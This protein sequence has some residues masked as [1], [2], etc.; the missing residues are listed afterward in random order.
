MRGEILRSGYLGK[1]F[2][3]QNILAVMSAAAFLL[4]AVSCG[5]V[6][7]RIPDNIGLGHSSQ[8]EESS[9]SD[10]D[11]SCAIPVFSE[12]ESMEDSS[13][14]SS[15]ESS[16]SEDGEKDQNEEPEEQDGNDGNEE[17]GFKNP[18]ITADQ[19]APAYAVVPNDASVKYLGRTE[20]SDDILWCAMS[21][22]GAEFEY[23][24]KNLEI[25]FCGDSSVGDYYNHRARI[26]VFVNGERA[27][28]QV[29]SDHETTVAVIKAEEP[30]DY[31]VKVVKLS[32]VEMSTVGIKSVNIDENESLSPSQQRSRRIEFIGDSIT[33][34]YGIDDT[35][36]NSGFSTSTEDIT[37]TYAYLA[38]QRLDADYSIFAIS[39]Y[40]VLSGWTSN[41]SQI[42]SSPL[43]P[44][45][46]S[47]LG[48]GSSSFTGHALPQ[49]IQW[50]FGRF[51]PDAIVINLG[52]ND[53]TYCRDDDDK[54]NAFTD[55]YVAFLKDIRANNPDA[56]I[57][58]I[59]GTCS[60]QIWTQVDRAAI[61][62][63]EETG[64]PNVHSLLI[65]SGDSSYGYA[66]SYHPSAASNSLMADVLY[67][68]IAQTMG[69]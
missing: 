64:D 34:G 54:L 33:C 2:S 9:A 39:G 24:G 30:A 53:S 25:T 6:P 20:L 41:P 18:Y 60:Q 11:S 38:A 62:Y 29:I 61:K 5:I 40:G 49:D 44:K 37:K 57:F 16:S 19:P 1:I 69:W 63:T 56:V 66:A 42:N 8:P 55:A 22:T 12:F 51:R 36:P 13:D 4:S 52:T 15:G 65:D 47:T 46:Y 10:S 67:E 3:K 35:N 14:D 48:C 50:D 26:G 7:Q 58:C 21:G 17:D 68:Q 43:I 27:V 59:L 31:N 45:Y 23:T 32:E 28:D